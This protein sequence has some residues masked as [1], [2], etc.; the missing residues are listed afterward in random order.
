MARR[1]KSPLAELASELLRGP[2]PSSPE[3]ALSLLGLLAGALNPG[4]TVGGGVSP[5]SGATATGSSPTGVSDEK[6]LRLA[7]ARYQA[8]VE[9]IPAVVFL[10]SLEGGINDIYVS[11]QIEALLGFTQREWS[12][13]PILWFRQLHPEDRPR[14][15][16]EFAMACITGRPFR[17]VARVF[18][19]EGRLV[20]VHTEAQLVR[21]ESG[22]PLFLHGVA[23]DITDQPQAQQTRQQLLRE[24]EA[25]AE[26]DL[27][28]ARLRETLTNLP[29]AIAVLAGPAHVVEFLNPVALELA[30]VGPEIIGR[31]WPAAFPGFP[32]EA[33]AVFDR[34]FSTG[35][36]FVA[37]EWRARSPEW[38]GERFFNFACQPLRDRR[39]VVT[40]LLTHAV[41]VT[42]QRQAQAAAEAALARASFLANASRV[43]GTSLD[44]ESTLDGL[45]R[46]VVPDVGD[47]SAVDVV[48]PDGSVK[49]VAVI[50]ADPAKAE[51]I[52]E[53]LDRHPEA[54]DAARGIGRVVRTGKPELVSDVDDALRTA[55]ARDAEHLRLLRELGLKSYITVPI[56]G[57]ARVHATLMVATTESGRRYGPPD[58]VMA[59]DIAQRAALAIEN[60]RLYREAQEAS[61]LKDEFLATLSHELR[62]PL[63]AIVGWA[64]ILRD[65]SE[66]S[67]PQTTKAVETIVRNAQIQ[68]QLISDILDVSRII[69]GKL[70]LRVRPVELAGVI[71]AALDTVRP[72]ADAKQIKLEA[73]LDASAGLVLAD[74]N[75]LQQVVWNLLVNAIKFSPRGGRVQVRLEEIDSHVEITVEDNGPGIDPEFLPFIFDRFRQAD[76]SSTRRH[77]GLGLGLAIVRHMVEL[78]G[79]T[80]EASNQAHRSGAVFK[81]RLPRRSVS[82]ESPLSSDRHPAEEETIWLESAPS[83]EGV[84]AL[85]VDDE[86]DA[87]ELIGTVLTRLGAQATTV[88]SA[89]E[90]YEALR[91]DR[92]DVL[93][94][95]IEMPEE[96]G[97]ELIRTVRNLPPEHGA[98]TPA[99]ALTAYA[100]AQDR[101]RALGAGF[102]MHVPKPV[103]PAELVA[104]VASLAKLA[105]R[106]T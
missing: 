38:P 56:R 96:D 74:P 84:K 46:L 55:P 69:A 73:I 28:G 12:A 57:R 19:R 35:E 42:A 22:R 10:A 58:V 81:V 87:R 51:G 88:G 79:G 77:G 31:P 24:Q 33:A 54:M 71:E 104:V 45:A 9:Q 68:S 13:N 67:S 62:T 65:Q 48:Q 43:L 99:V 39:G 60:A 5:P 6:Q 2:G 18:S 50:H 37:R 25:R 100:S 101:V 80:V 34:V 11:P 98:L 3:E 49:T 29:A 66:A 89:A 94:A 85:I 83:L 15:S 75:R 17:G 52:R 72:A 61:R 30:G 16:R 86:P 32:E 7:E 95:D 64:H 53:L 21:D 82:A 103:Q 90:A 14:L 63:N 47:L 27:E 76:S 8:L 97:Y 105:T 93:L 4:R 1:D 70:A 41:E 26:S 20:W 78:H 23:F 102:Q 106:R 36:P 91:R 44:Y 59:E 92:F 40:G